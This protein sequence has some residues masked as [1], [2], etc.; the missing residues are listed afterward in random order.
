[1]TSDTSSVLEFPIQAGGSSP[2]VY[3]KGY[4]RGTILLDPANRYAEPL[5]DYRTFTNPTDV[6]IAIETMRWVRRYWQTPSA[7][8]LGPVEQSPGANLMS[9]A[10]LEE[11]VRRSTSSTTAHLSG[12]NSMM[13]RELGGVVSPEL[14]VYGVT[15]LSVGDSSIMPLIPGAHICSSVYAVAEK[16]SYL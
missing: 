10:D 2:L 8:S 14:T 9:D 6:Q 16:V 13:P 1:M 4:S 15:G 11:A 5:L 12:T 3:T 7:Q